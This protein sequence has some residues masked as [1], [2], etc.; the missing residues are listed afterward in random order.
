[1]A[2]LLF[3][4][5]I[6]FMKDTITILKKL[7]S[8]PTVT[9]NHDANRE[10]LNWVHNKLSFLEG[11]IESIN[12]F[13]S[14]YLST[15][16]T[17]SPDILL[18]AHID[19]VNGFYELTE[20]DEKIYGRGVFD[21]KF[22]IASFIVALN[23]L[24]SEMSSLNLAV[25]ITSDEEVGGDNGTKAFI[26]RG[27]R[28][29]VVVL[30]DGSENWGFEEASKGV[31]QLRIESKGKTGHGAYPWT[32]KN[33]VEEIVSFLIELKSHFPTEPCD[34]EDHRHSTMNIGKIEG[35]SVANQ[36][37]DSA[38]ALVDIR[39]T[40]KEERN[41]IADVI[42][43]ITDP[44]IEIN[45]LVTGE[46]HNIDRKNPYLLSFTGTVKDLLD[47]NPS[48]SISHGASD[49]RFFATEKIPVIL[50]RPRGGEAHG[51]GEWIEA[52]DVERF[53][54]VIEK[55]IKKEFIDKTD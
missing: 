51:E 44:N 3:Y 31:W 45:T 33:A 19:V 25:L 10:A 48:F 37:P 13:P 41:R 7:V 46:A 4:D 32:G 14:L 18:A 20:K 29:K 22:A 40:S 8:M 49:A 5:I 39:F 55:F 12:G 38:Y 23:R 35:G 6:F 47:I 24:R 43:R 36:I 42:N 54:E 11:G 53:T 1:M 16:G 15:K 27:L 34:I 26:D 2:Y 30:P 28:P 52:E 17:F 21:M 9:H 50:T